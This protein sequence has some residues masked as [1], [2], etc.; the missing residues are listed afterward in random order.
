MKFKNIILAAAAALL[1][2]SCMTVHKEEIPEDRIDM[3]KDYALTMVDNEIAEPFSLLAL[4]IRLDGY[5]NS[6]EED[7]TLANW[8][9]LYGNVFMNEAGDLLVGGSYNVSTGYLSLKETG[10][11]WKY[12]NLGWEIACTGPS[13]WTCRKYG[14][15]ATP[16]VLVATLEDPAEGLWGLDYS[17]SDVYEDKKAVLKS[18]SLIGFCS[19]LLYVDNQSLYVN[20]SIASPMV[21]GKVRADFYSGDNTVDFIEVEYKDGGVFFKTSRD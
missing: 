9:D 19:G 13:T 2:S 5:I 8:P 17:S 12:T 4:S 14:D 15:N 6:K 20:T 1:A 3:M 21:R 16:G 11:S 10:M 18:D 7:R